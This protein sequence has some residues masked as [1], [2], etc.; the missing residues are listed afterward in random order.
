[1]EKLLT[2]YLYEFKNC[3]LPGIGSLVLNPG[4]AYFLPGEKR[5]IAPIPFI[6]L[7]EKETPVEPLQ[8]FIASQYKISET[9]AAALLQDYSKQLLHINA[10]EEQALDNAGSF[11]MDEN[12]KLHFKSLSLPAA[13]FPDVV[14][15]RVVHPDVAHAML[16]GDTHTNSTAMTEL[17]EH[18][19]AAKSRWWMVAA[20]LAVA[21]VAAI[22]FYYSSHP[23]GQSGNGMKAKTT[24]EAKTYRTPD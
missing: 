6:S 4:H 15:E 7:E 18:E 10:Y 21:A 5:M 2:N 20:A 9:E 11:Y 24:T 16:V 23:A 17:L 19:P 1:M 22:I 14:A 8:D 3:P 13:Y 12:S